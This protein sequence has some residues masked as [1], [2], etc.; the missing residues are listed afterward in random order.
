[1]EKIFSQTDLD[2][3][4]QRGNSL[5]AVMQQLHFFNHGIPKI[6]LLK[7]ATIQDGIWKF[8]D[9]EKEQFIQYFDKHKSKYQITKFVPASGAASRMFQFLSEFLNIFNPETDTINSYVNKYE[10]NN[11]S[12]FIV[13]LRNFPFYH[14]LKDTTK[15]N[16]TDYPNYSSDKKIYV[17]IKTLLEKQGLNYVQKPKG[18]L[19]FHTY[20]D[21]IITAVEEQIFETDFYK[22]KNQKTNIHFTISPE[23]EKDFVKI[24]S[25]YENINYS[26]SYQDKKTD[27]IAVNA[28][29]TPYRTENGELFFRPGGHGALIENLN[30]LQTDYAFIKNIDNVSQNNKSI[31]SNYKKLLGGILLKVQYQIF[32]YLE[33]LEKKNITNKELT[34]IKDFI[35]TKLCFPLIEEFAFFQEDFQ[36][37]YLF[38]ILNR[39]IR[40]CGMVK[41]EGEPGG[42]PFWVKDGKGRASLQIVESSQIDLQNENQKNILQSATHFNPVDIVCALKDYKG[43]KFNL[44]DFIDHEAAFITEK[45]K[46]GK[47][48]KAIE[49]PGLWNGA[50]AKWS[51][52]FVEVPLETFSPVKTVNDLLKPAH[53]YSYE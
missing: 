18:V 13:G 23:H 36:K 26:F 52:I 6:E 42:G 24:L 4:L 3:I 45:N 22:V 40:V 15:K 46:N 19:P 20:E 47:P 51:T 5:D 43:N 28:D 29:N 50:M 34:E 49:L 16:Y 1:M 31:I 8:D 10:D 35:E 2:Y 9:A 12:M 33:A 17:I 48:I 14:N 37:Q 21:K 53:Q 41:N 44:I 7:C 11:L 30:Q 32:K 25:V 38:K 27:T 39:P